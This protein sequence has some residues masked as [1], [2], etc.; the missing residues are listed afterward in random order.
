MTPHTYVA[1]FTDTFQLQ[2]ST[3]Y[4]TS[5]GFLRALAVATRA[6][7]QQ[8]P[9][10]YLGLPGPDRMV[11]LYR[12]PEAVFH[13]ET[14]SSLRGKAVTRE[15]PTGRQS[16]TPENW[17]EL[18]V[19]HAG[20]N[21]LELEDGRL[22]VWIT[23]IEPGAIR[24]VEAGIDEISMGSRSNFSPFVAED[25]TALDSYFVDS[26]IDINH[27]ALIPPG[28]GR[29][30]R[31]VRVMDSREGNMAPIIPQQPQAPPAAQPQAGQAP[32]VPVPPQAQPVPAFQGG[33]PVF[34]GGT[35]SFQAPTQPQ[36]PQ[37][38]MVPQ[39]V[40]PQQ[41]LGFGQP[42]PPQVQN[43]PITSFGYAGQQ[44]P[45][46]PQPPQLMP[47]PAMQQA[48]QQHN[49]AIPPPDQVPQGAYP[50]TAT[51]LV[52]QAPPQPIPVTPQPPQPPTGDSAA[53]PI[54]EDSRQ[55]A[56]FQAAVASKVQLLNDCMPFLDDATK[57][58]AQTLSERDLL[59]AATADLASNGKDL[60]DDFLRGMLAIKIQQQ[61]KQAQQ[62][63][64]IQDAWQGA[65]ESPA[66]AGQQQQPVDP[67]AGGLF[68]DSLDMLI[69]DAN[70]DSP[71]NNGAQ[72][73]ARVAAD[74]IFRG[75]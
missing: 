12:P 16:V 70:T 51:I 11:G 46:Q 3:R 13:D 2:T 49:P 44:P 9:S 48:V 34:P 55:A 30:G 72:M 41:G 38:Y 57:A 19:G 66:G 74:G 24:D 10:R 63:D 21:I 50:P 39:Q 8:Y 35:Q 73:P 33:A 5:E 14:K 1:N 65:A 42:T 36:Q 64:S 43:Q 22:A 60:P 62:Q 47:P 71:R 6:G 45:Q 56:A 29:A 7:T 17:K 27:M 54:I 28:Q 75:A 52:G 40:T 25:G 53:Q 68:R 59:I 23:L 15:H 58:K 32:V 37:Q 69:S 26:P 18:A 67:W 4:Y 20:D 61:Q 31:D